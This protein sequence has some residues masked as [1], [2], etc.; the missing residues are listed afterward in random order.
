M[1]LTEREKFIAHY[2]SVTIVG[3]MDQQSNEAVGPTIDKLKITR[4]RKLNIEEIQKIVED[5]NEEFLV[6]GA[7]LT[8]QHKAREEKDDW[9]H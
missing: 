2:L 7:L 1:T 3:M 6:S 8:G 9:D 4:S 5:L